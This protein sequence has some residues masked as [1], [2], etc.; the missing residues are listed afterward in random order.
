MSQRAQSIVVRYAIALT[1]VVIALA[2]AQ[3]L[4]PEEKEHIPSV[5]FLAAVTVSAWYGGIGPGLLATILSGLAL[6]YYFVPEIGTIGL[7]VP[8]LVWLGAY[9]G[10]AILISLSQGMQRRLIEALRMQNR[11]KSEFMAVLAHEMR[12]FLSPVATSIDILKLS[13]DGEPHSA[14]ACDT[15]ERQIGN[16]TQL[17]NDLLDVAR[18]TQGKAH[19]NVERVDLAA[20]AARAVQAVQPLITSRDQ[21]L[22]MSFPTGPLELDAD[23]TRLEQI[24]INLL[25]NAAKYTNPGGRIW[26]AIERRDPDWVIRVRDNGKGIPADV[27]PHI[28]DLFMQAEDG[29]QGG[30]GIGLSLVRGLVEMHGGTIA[31]HSAG[32]GRGSEFVVRLPAANPAKQTEPRTLPAEKVAG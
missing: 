11:R 32:L 13:R 24:L 23:P 14:E 17:I 29:S 18:V 7:R 9:A 31:A 6:D 3:F 26:L 15:I 8:S 12:N 27:L 1:S 16:M 10:V 22:E 4:N 25:T 28:F 2:I 20:V 5:I 21:R 30:L 19:L